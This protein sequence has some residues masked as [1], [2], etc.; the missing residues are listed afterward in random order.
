MV[1]LTIANYHKYQQGTGDSALHKCD[2]PTTKMQ[3][4]KR[5][6]E[7]RRGEEEAPLEKPLDEKPEEKPKPQSSG[8]DRLDRFNAWVVAHRDEIKATMIQGRYNEKWFGAEFPRMRTWIIA[9]PVKGNKK[10]WARFVDNWLK[11]GW[12]EYLKSLNHMP[13]GITSAEEQ[14]HYA[15]QRRSGPTSDFTGVGN[16]LTKIPGGEE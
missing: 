10:Q 11:T 13:D 14:A 12:E 8:I 7:K 5:R 3:T 16:I 9:N 1:Y 2:T 6:V 4:E 15:G